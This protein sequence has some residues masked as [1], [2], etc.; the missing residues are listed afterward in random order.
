MGDNLY[1]RIRR[2]AFH[3][4]ALVVLMLTGLPVYRASHGDHTGI[5]KW[6]DVLL[7]IGVGVSFMV[8][9]YFS[10]LNA[11]EM[12]ED[13]KVKEIGSLCDVNG[14]LHHSGLKVPSGTK[15][16]ISDPKRAAG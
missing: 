8:A 4:S 6:S 13:K 7:I 1:F 9:C 14:L 11:R 12:S 16:Y 3:V 15:F 2:I 10:P 5:P